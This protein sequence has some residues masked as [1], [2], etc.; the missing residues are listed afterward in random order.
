MRLWTC[1]NKNVLWVCHIRLF[2]CPRVLLFIHQTDL[3]Q[4]RVCRDVPEDVGARSFG[5]LGI[6]SCQPAINAMNFILGSRLHIPILCLSTF[7]W[8]CVL[9][10]K[11]LVIQKIIFVDYILSS[12]L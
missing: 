7:G 8:K 3:N 2:V 10:Y 12:G 9:P 5:F 6:P 11:L 4:D 1:A